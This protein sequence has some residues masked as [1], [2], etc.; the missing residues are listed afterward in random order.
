MRAQHYN[1]SE[2]WTALQKDG[3]TEAVIIEKLG[4]R[5]DKRWEQRTESKTRE[6]C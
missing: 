4:I 6:E 5:K 2:K 3:E 1:N